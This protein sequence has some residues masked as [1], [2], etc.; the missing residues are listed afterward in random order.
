MKNTILKRVPSADLARNRRVTLDPA[1]MEQARV[2]VDDVARRGFAA[3]REHARSL[4]DLPRGAQA[5]YSAAD[6]EAAFENLPPAERRL[7]ERTAGRIA[8]FARAQKACLHEL[9]HKVPGGT[10]GHR[11]NALESCGCYVP[12]G[13]FPLPSSVLMTAVTARV[14]GVRRV[15]AA[16]PRPAP[17]TLAAAW[18]AGA[19]ALLA[20]GG[21]QAVA[22]M[23]FGADPVPACDTLVGPGNR[24]VTAA[25]QL[26]CGQVSIDML[27]GPSELCVLADET[28]DADLVAADLL[29]QA[30]H[31]PD[32]TCVL[33]TLR[34]ELIG[35]VENRLDA[36]LENL[37]TAEVAG[38]SLSAG[39]ATCCADLDEAI[40]ACDAL[41]PEHLQL[42]V[43]DVDRVAQRLGNYGAL[44]IGPHSAEVFGDY[45]IGPNHVLPTGGGARFTGGLSVLN[46]LRVQTWLRVGERGAN[47]QVAED[48]AALA[49]LEGLE[50]HARAAEGRVT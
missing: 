16:S 9:S 47:A 38:Q 17:V 37:P 39:L 5:I 7:L 27:A 22:A 34:E 36:Q 32:A 18:V 2:I 23:A 29:A 30:E 45:G 49:R 44:F 41:A 43:A 13:R 33:V 46:F 28:A 26:V 19:D 40:A 35:E 12:G 50:A 10:A 15:W 4:G 14:A 1:T 6:L 20:V 11:V 31:D 42:V 21:A 24:W 48:A 8:V 25:K 3:V